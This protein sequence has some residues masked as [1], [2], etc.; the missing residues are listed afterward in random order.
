MK[1]LKAIKL[2]LMSFVL[3]IIIFLILCCDYLG[4]L[5]RISQSEKNINDGY[6]IYSIQHEDNPLD[7]D[8][9][10]FKELH[11][12]L[13]EDNGYKYFEIYKQ[14]LEMPNQK[15]L[16]YEEGTGKLLDQC[17]GISCI[18]ISEDMIDNCEIIISDG[19][20]FISDDFIYKKNEVI[21]VLMGK[22][23]SSLYCI[24]DIFEAEYLFDKYKFKIIGF[25]SDA[26]NI[27]MASYNIIL[28]KYIVMPSFSIDA[29]VSITDGLKIHYANKTSGIIRLSETN[30]NKFYTDI[31]PL[32]ENVKTGNYSWT[33]TPTEIQYKD[34]FNISIN[35]SRAIIIIFILLLIL[36]EICLVYNFSYYK[37]VNLH[38]VCRQNVFYSIVLLVFTSILCI[39]FNLVSIIILGINLIR[40]NHFVYIGLLSI[41][42]VLLNNLFYKYRNKR[43]GSDVPF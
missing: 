37:L 35:Q 25:L 38:L 31:V 22:E 30:I 18:Q 19:T 11:K 16:F 2:V 8:L 27:R 17:A 33:V 34:M 26:S 4:T 21:P 24:G 43:N 15:G 28:D 20:S 36:G 13:I 14:Y 32:L 29:N 39:F 12:L 41:V 6:V 1:A 5:L 40:N 9:E 23:Y 10:S 42:I 3:A 7:K